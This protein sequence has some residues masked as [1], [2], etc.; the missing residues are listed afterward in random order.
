MMKLQKKCEEAPKQ[1]LHMNNE[2]CFYI[3][4]TLPC[5]ALLYPASSLSYTFSVHACYLKSHQGK[6]TKRMQ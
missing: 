3:L 4:H 1:G 5:T 2:R 6:G